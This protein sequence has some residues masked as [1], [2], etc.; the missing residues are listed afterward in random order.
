MNKKGQVV[1]CHPEIRDDLLQKWGG[2]Y[3]ID[4]EE[5]GNKFYAFDMLHIGGVN[6]T[7]R[8]FQDRHEMLANAILTGRDS[9]SLVTVPL[10][11]TEAEKRAMYAKLKAD[12][13]EG[14]VFKC[15]SAR[16]TQ[17][18]PNSGGDQFKFK[19]WKSATCIVTKV[20]DA[21]SV[22]VSG[23][24]DSG[25]LVPLGNCSIQVN[26]SIPPVGRLIEVKYLYYFAGGS[27]FQPSYKGVRDDCDYSD[28]H[29]SKLH[30]KRDGVC[31]S[32]SLE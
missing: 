32:S 23:I 6:L 24:D 26:R 31:Y 14:I 16:V 27:L 8:S 13:R 17:G 4:G 9:T 30:L 3:H 12:G 20:N 28:C 19:F 10:A 15:L 1:E 18:R 7:M 11:K 25:A 22:A 2:T 29:I 5:I 21:R